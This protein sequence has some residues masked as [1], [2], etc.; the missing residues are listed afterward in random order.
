MTKLPAST[1]NPSAMFFLK[2]YLR[3]PFGTGSITPSSKKLGQ[4]IVSHLDLKPHEFVVE[5]GPGTG[6]FTRELLAKGVAPDKLILVEFNV[7]FASY[8]RKE[9]PAVRVVE[10]DAGNLPQVLQS[11]GY[12]K[13]HRIVSGI[14]LRSLKPL[15]RKQIT[16]A[17]AQSLEVGGVAVQFSYLKNSPFPLKVASECG[18][19]GKRVGMALGNVPPAFVWKY[20]KLP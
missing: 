8:L 6:V 15:Q 14:P 9:F 1:D 19:Q 7:D 3:K 4:V 20:I 2:Q 18:L 11:I 5:L 13:V 12:S 16:E 17:I 10:G